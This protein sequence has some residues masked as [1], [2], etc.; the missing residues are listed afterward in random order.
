MIRDRRA[1]APEI[2]DDALMISY[3]ALCPGGFDF[4]LLD[5]HREAVQELMS[6]LLDRGWT[7][8]PPATYIPLH[9]CPVD[10]EVR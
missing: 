9:C 3:R 4:P 1:G 8:C 7:I 5:D 10:R 2:P 6:V